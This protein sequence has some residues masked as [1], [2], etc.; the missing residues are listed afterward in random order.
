MQKTGNAP[1]LNLKTVIYATDFSPDSQNAGLYAARIAA[2]FSAT[3]LVAHAFTLS[4]AA[5]EVESGDRLVSRQRKDLEALLARKASLLASDAVKAVP[6]LLDGEPEDALL[7]LADLHGP[8]MIAL[9][10]HGGGG[11]KRKLIGSVAENLL[12]STHWPALTVGPHVPLVSSKTLPFERI[13]YVANFTPE[14]A[15]AA[16]FAI[17]FTER[18]GASIDVLHV[19]P[20]E[21]GQD[22][23]QLS[24]LRSRFF[25]AL[26]GMAQQ[27]GGDFCDPKTF[28]EVDESHDRILKHIAERKIDLLILGIRK[29]SLF[30][31]E[32]T[33]SFAFQIVV[34]AQC[35]VLTIR[36]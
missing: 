11:M 35:P 20:A 1:A 14:A 8:S 19:I 2:C 34:N 21:S 24:D 6:V 26:E 5:M 31:L 3:L 9:G 29:A 13:L 15:N 36:H 10:T 25:S 23:E 17:S 32:M 7:K 27:H 16:A 4:Q 28:V 33:G 18:L 30:G 22:Q 12:E